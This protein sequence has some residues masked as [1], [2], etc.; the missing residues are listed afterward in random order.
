MKLNYKSVLVIAVVTMF[1]AQGAYA[2]SLKLKKEQMKAQEKIDKD[3]ASI[4]KNCG[5]AP[6][7]DID[8]ESFKTSDDVRISYANMSHV[9]G[10]MSQ[11][12]KQFKK[13]V[14]AGIKSVKIG[15]SPNMAATLKD[16]TLDIKVTDSSRVYGDSSIQKLI[17]ENL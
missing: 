7:V 11:V 13:E 9:N 10:G 15:K 1:G 2:L 16:G 17:E 3:I 6:K 4:N 8:W 12:C 14:C 5:C